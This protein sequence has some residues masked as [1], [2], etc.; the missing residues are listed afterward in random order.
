[1]IL[2]GVRRVVMAMRDPNPKVAG[3][4]VARLRAAGI[5]V[6]EDVLR[7]EAAV[8]NEVFIKYI[9]TRR[10]FVALKVAM[11]LDG[12]IAT[13]TGDSRWIT[14]R[15]ARE[16]VHRLRDTYDAILV[17]IGTVLKDDPSLTT[18]LPDGGRDPVRIVLD[19]MAR[20]PVA[21]RVLSVELPA[22]VIV[23]ATSRAPETRVAELESRG[24]KVIRCGG[25]S[26]VDLGVLLRELAA[27]RISSVL[28]EGGATVHASFLETGLVDKLHW[29]VA[30]KI[31]GGA[32]APGAVAGR[33]IERISEAIRLERVRRLE[34]GE[35][36]CI[37][38]YP[39]SGGS[40]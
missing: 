27:G 1:V 39:A 16:Y 9:T 33:G 5:E 18:R 6:T 35:D 10:P 25:G 20:I 28:V 29:F 8:V 13:R 11:S 40:G 32:E 12:K 24:A 15:A 37:E 34:F 36:L 31:I 14:G 3:K 2:A 38:G 30:P 17:G 22:T 26:A 23:A 4:G 7:D 19:S 21:A